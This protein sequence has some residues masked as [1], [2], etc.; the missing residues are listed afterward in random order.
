[1]LNFVK[2]Q[3]SCVHSSSWIIL[4]WFRGWLLSSVFT[5]GLVAR[6]SQWWLKN[7]AGYSQ[8]HKTKLNAET[9]QNPKTELST[10]ITMKQ[11][12][13]QNPLSQLVTWGL[14]KV[15]RHCWTPTEQAE[16]RANQGNT[17]EPL[18]VNY[19][20]PD[21]GTSALESGSLVRERGSSLFRHGSWHGTSV[22]PV[23]SSLSQQRSQ[24][25]IKRTPIELKICGYVPKEV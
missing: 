8:Q 7:T 16:A 22:Q 5:V 14:E 13:T 10:S 2:R 17:S 11:E 9:L 24:N 12:L 15:P 23:F 3:L 19:Q 4:A 6:C 1:M 20:L 18:E 25:S 21:C